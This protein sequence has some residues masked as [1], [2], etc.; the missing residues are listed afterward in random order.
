MVAAVQVLRLAGCGRGIVSGGGRSVHFETRAPQ[1]RMR[2]STV[3]YVLL[4]NCAEL[5]TD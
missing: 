4:V 2:S 3:L 1:E 5:L